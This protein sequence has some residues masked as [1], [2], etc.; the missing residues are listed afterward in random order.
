MAPGFQP[1][2]IACLGNYIPRQ[3]GIATFNYDTRAAIAGAD[4][5]VNAFV[6]AVN[7][8]HE[9]YDYPPE[10]RFQFFQHD[11]EA[12]RRAADYL[13]FSDVDL[14]CVQHEFGIYG[15]PAG[16]YL[17]PLLR[18]LRMPVVTILHTV[19]DNPDPDQRRVILELAKL[20]ARLIVMSERGKRFLIDIYGIQPAKIA[21]VPHGIPDTPFIDPNFNKDKFGVEGRPTLLTFGLLSPGKGLEYVIKALPKIVEHTPDV[22][23]MVVG[24]THPNLV[25]ADG[26]S[27]RES[28]Q[29]LAEELGVAENLLF[30]N[31]FVDIKELTEFIGVSDIYITPYLNP[32]QI[33]SGTLAYSF[34]SGKAVISTPYWHAEE[35][36]S[37][38][39]GVLVPFR[40]SEAIADAVIDLFQ[41]ESKRHRIRKTA[42]ELGREMVWSEIGKRLQKIFEEA[43]TA[44][45]R[46]QVSPTLPRRRYTI[47]PLQWEHLLRLT[48]STGL[49]QHATYTMPNFAEG[50]CTDDN[51]RA[52][53]F[54]LMVDELDQSSVE[55]QRAASAYQAFL[56][57][58][59]DPGR[60]RFRNFLSFDRRWLEEVGSDD[61]HGRALWALGSCVGRSK[62]SST[63]CWATQLF[64]SA[65]R[66]MK[67]IG[68][69]RSWAFALLGIDEYLRRLD[70]DRPVTEMRSELSARL[71]RLYNQVAANDWLW[72]EDYLTYSNAKLSQAMIVTGHATGNHEFLDCGLTSLKWLSEIQQSESGHLRSIGC[73]GFYRRGGS[74]AAFDQQPLEAQGMVS[75][76][77]AAWRATRDDDWLRSAQTA[78][79]W[80][81]GANDLGVPVYDTLTGG[82][83]DGLQCDSMNK[84]QGAESTLAYLL[85][86]AEL[87][88]TAGIASRELAKGL[89]TEPQGLALPWNS[90]HR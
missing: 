58:A 19:L 12:Y 10:V 27:Y 53:V 21:V 82:C 45:V 71:L 6:V 24:A 73:N 49:F 31:R 76:S 66:A 25:R 36:L 87:M 51:A 29:H 37:D 43:G 1:R 59:Y 84:N 55:L 20:S 5:Q 17:I 69:P 35:L 18:D 33:T 85:S 89:A 90:T 72:F 56:N 75:A 67:D 15:G 70:G 83:H 28:L 46:K 34:G 16:S 61:A 47:P 60:G 65:L 8:S 79:E 14:V 30:Y 26:E 80:F 41:D 62:H 9:G 44:H 39:R 63:Q 32:A 38:G 57:Y 22:A 3:C 74:P 48:D 50:Y 42:Y 88:Q 11:R 64:A 2:N 77:L 23:Y 68:S 13:N 7:D 81:L 54:T 40:D 78:F 4:R 52:L 86:L